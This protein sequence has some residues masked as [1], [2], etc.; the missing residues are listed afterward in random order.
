MHIPEDLISIADACKI[1]GCTEGR[2]RQ[3][4]KAGEIEGEQRMGRTWIVSRKSVE[5]RAKQ[6]KTVGRPRV[7]EREAG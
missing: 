1:L 7:S 5:R 3:L 6:P 2:V 4:L